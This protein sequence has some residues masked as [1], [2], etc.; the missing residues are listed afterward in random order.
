MGKPGGFAGHATLRTDE[1]FQLL[2][3]VVAGA[4]GGLVAVIHRAHMSLELHADQ[5]SGTCSI[6]STSHPH[7]LKSP[8]ALGQK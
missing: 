5:I 7:I 4:R 1:G 8:M 2:D 3:A 6:I